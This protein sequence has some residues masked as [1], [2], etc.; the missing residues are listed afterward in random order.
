MRECPRVNETRDM[1]TV[2]SK[3]V[4]V[5]GS[6]KSFNLYASADWG[7]KTYHW[8]KI[9][10]THLFRC[11]GRA[12]IALSCAFN[13]IV[14]GRLR[15]KLKITCHLHLCTCKTLDPKKCI[16]HK[17]NFR[18]STCWRAC[19]HFDWAPKKGRWHTWSSSRQKSVTPSCCSSP[20][21]LSPTSCLCSRSA[22]RVATQ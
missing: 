18:I 8:T 20:A 11:S 6:Q 21:F 9:I 5:H 10:D 13:I 4:S 19:W 15:T 22:G 2:K 3:C 16:S 1:N 17:V 12:F 14:D 7:V